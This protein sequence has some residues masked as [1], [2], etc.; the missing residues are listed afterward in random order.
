MCVWEVLGC[1]ANGGTLVLRD[2]SPTPYS[3]P[4]FASVPLTEPPASTGSTFKRNTVSGWLDLLKSVDVMIAT[5][6]ILAKFDPKELSNIRT[7]AV[8]G[9]PCSRPLADD[10]AIGRD[11]YNCCGPTEVRWLFSSINTFFM[12]ITS[13]L[14]QRV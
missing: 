3:S 14:T 6:S 13:A 11:F 8:A 1:L 7:V 2:S 9:E 10:W 4:A 12:T 5:P